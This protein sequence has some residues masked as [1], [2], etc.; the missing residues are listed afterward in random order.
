[1][2]EYA[3]PRDVKAFAEGLAQQQLLC[4]TYGHSFNPFT[5]TRAKT[6]GK[7][8]VYYEQILRCKCKV[9][10][11]LLLSSRGSVISST[12]DYT[13]APGY[14]TK[15][16]GRVVGEGRDVLRLESITRLIERK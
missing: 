2:A 5:V 16:I 11:R 12:Y 4:R 3:K 15:G 7:R 13:D 14:L 10:R 9:K 8:S 1:M 6:E